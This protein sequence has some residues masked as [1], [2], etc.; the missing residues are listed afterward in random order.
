MP[1]PP[2]IEFAVKS[3]L[4]AIAKRLEPLPPIRVKALSAAWLCVKVS[5][6]FP[7]TMVLSPADFAL[8]L[9]VNEVPLVRESAST[10]ER[11]AKLES[12]RIVDDERLMVSLPTPPLTVLAFRTTAREK[13]KESP[14]EDPVSELA[15]SDETPEASRVRAWLE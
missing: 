14:S 6:P 8:P 3:D 5:S 2:M 1:V 9:K 7:P 10:P 4:F 13:M 12:A 11:F 15:L